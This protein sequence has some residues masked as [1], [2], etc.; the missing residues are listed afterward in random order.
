M[1]YY[2]RNI[3]DYAKKAGRLSLLQHGV[4]NLL[5]DA[6]Y[7]REKFPTREQAVDWIWASTEEELAALDFVLSKFFENRDGIFVQTRIEEE[8]ENYKDFCKL[9]AERGKSG[10][11]PK[12]PAG[13]PPGNQRKANES[14]T[15]NQEPITNN[16]KPRTKDRG[17]MKRPALSEVL[18]E[19]QC[20][21]DNP[22]AE[23]EKFLNYYESNGWKVGKNPMKSWKHAV[24]NW[25]TRSKQNGNQAGNGISRSSLSRSDEARA[26]IDRLFD[27]GEDGSIEGDYEEIG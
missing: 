8:I 5:I 14:L 17:R 1:H 6:C 11:R 22:K 9:Q 4:Y 21:V 3:G 26:E 10:G 12:K 20:R 27:A 13:N 15:T 23:A 19:F 18:Q 24:T 7:D 25:I 2:K 16:H